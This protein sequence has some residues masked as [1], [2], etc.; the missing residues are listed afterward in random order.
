MTKK[1]LKSARFQIFKDTAGEYR[2][3][4]LS[5]NGAIQADS[6]EGYV[7]K[8]G[9]K[10]AIGSFLKSLGVTRPLPIEEVES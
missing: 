3:R 7:R 6:A 2:W 4:L 9:C 1:P 5:R 10:R 8:Y